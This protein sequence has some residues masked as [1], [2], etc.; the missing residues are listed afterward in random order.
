MHNTVIKYKEHDSNSTIH[1]DL[2][3]YVI[4]FGANA[5][6]NKI[7][8]FYGVECGFSRE[9]LQN[10][11]KYLLEQFV[12]TGKTSIQLYPAALDTY[13]LAFCEMIY[14]LTDSAKREAFM[15][16][17]H[18]TDYTLLISKLSKLPLEQVFFDVAKIL[19][20]NDDIL[21]ALMIRLN[22]KVM[23]DIPSLYSIQ[24]NIL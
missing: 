23:S 2:S 17:C 24:E 6:P 1:L 8:I 13:T 10:D 16:L 12:L 21:E 5:A 9:F 14:S 18:P 15:Q 20:H 3:K 4:S 22:G 11:F 7:E 19:Q